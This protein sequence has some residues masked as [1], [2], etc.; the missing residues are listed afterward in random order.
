MIIRTQICTKT[1]GIM[2]MDMSSTEVFA[3]GTAAKRVVPTGGVPRPMIKFTTIT[4]AKCSGW[5]PTAIAILLRIGPRIK[6]LA[7]TSN[8]IPAKSI[9]MFKI[10]KIRY[11]FVVI[12]VTKLL[13]RVGK[14]NTVSNHPKGADAPTIKRITPAVTPL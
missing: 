5:T 6:I 14:S 2:A 3:R 9:I 10:N 12:P 1:N 4:N 13:M 11:L 7:V 8:N